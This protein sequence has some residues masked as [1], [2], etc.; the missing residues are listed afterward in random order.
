MSIA[1]T[2]DQACCLPRLFPH[3]I[4]RYG[5]TIHSE[6]RISYFQPIHG[7]VPHVEDFNFFLFLNDLVDHAID[8]RLGAIKHVSEA[9]V[10]GRRRRALGVVS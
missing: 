8:M 2:V 7:A 9:F 4:M 3:L 10:L 1:S 6:P 5:A